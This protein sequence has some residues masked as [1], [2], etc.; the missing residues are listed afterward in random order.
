LLEEIKQLQATLKKTESDT[1]ALKTDLVKEKSEKAAAQA[2]L[3]ALKTKKPDTSEAD[4]LR[5]EL[6]ALNNE[7][8]AALTKLQEELAKATKEHGTTKDALAKAQAEVDEHKAAVEKGRQTSQTDYK[9]L[10]DSMTQLVEEANKKAADKEALIAELEANLK[11]K[12]AEIAELK[13]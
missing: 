1:E 5:K 13:V 6:Q 7:H 11:V 12:D 10:H 3:D 9:D 8:Q 2:D 4:A